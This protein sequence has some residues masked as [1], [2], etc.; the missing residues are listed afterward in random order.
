MNSGMIGIPKAT[1]SGLT[2]SY[3]IDSTS[4]L[5]GMLR[6]ESKLNPSLMVITSLSNWRLVLPHM[7]LI[8]TIPQF[9]NEL[10]YE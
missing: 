7:R 6:L 10:N 3:L 4:E 5:G 9:V 1:E 2:V 8:S